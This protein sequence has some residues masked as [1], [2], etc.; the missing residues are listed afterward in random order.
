MISSFGARG[1]D[2]ESRSEPEHSYMASVADLMIGLLFVFI[3]MV[4]FLA[5][6]KKNEMAAAEALVQGARDPRGQVTEAIGEAIRATL[7]SVRVDPASGVISMPEDLL[8]D[9]GSSTLKEGAQAKLAEV[10]GVLSLVLRCYVASERGRLACPDNEMGHEIETVFIEGH[11]DNLPMMRPGGNAKLS[12]DRALSVSV[13]MIDS[14]VLADFRNDQQ[15]PIFSHSA[16]AD[17]RPLKGVDP[18]D[19]RNRRVDLRIILS[20]R[21]PTGL[22]VNFEESAMNSG[23]P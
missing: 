7:P 10:A 6:Q 8:F 21:P 12:L 5:L 4:A 3:I 16:Y 9:R 17:S 1:V 2:V 18:S 23:R 22:S 15:Q 19:G 13:A 20:Y 11:T 14:T